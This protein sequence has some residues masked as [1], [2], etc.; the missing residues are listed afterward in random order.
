[1]PALVL[2]I[3]EMLETTP[4]SISRLRHQS[5][6]HRQTLATDKQGSCKSAPQHTYQDI[7]CLTTIVLNQIKVCF[8]LPVLFTETMNYNLKTHPIQ[9]CRKPQYSEKSPQPQGSQHD[10]PPGLPHKAT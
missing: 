7:V 6:H 5:A 10:H 9:P 4:T 8:E 1:M 3:K 2:L